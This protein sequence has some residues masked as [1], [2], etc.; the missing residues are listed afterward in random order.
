MDLVLNNLQRVI[1]HK[2]QQTNLNKKANKV[3]MINLKG[4]QGENDIIST[5][6]FLSFKFRCRSIRTYAGIANRISTLTPQP[7]VHHNSFRVC[8]LTNYTQ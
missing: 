5:I 4:N 8:L 2:T 3:H 7:L 6:C 1:C